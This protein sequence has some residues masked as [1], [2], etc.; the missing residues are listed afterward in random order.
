MATRANWRILHPIPY[1]KGPTPDSV[2]RAAK[3][4][5][6]LDID[7]RACRGERRPDGSYRDGVLVGLHGK[8]PGR[9]GFRW[10]QESVQHGIPQSKVGDLVDRPIS[11]LTPE[12]VWTLRTRD[13]D[14]IWSVDHLIVL[15][16]KVGAKLEF[17]AKIAL[18]L[19]Q[20]KHLK[21]TCVAAYGADDWRQMVW[22]K[23]LTNI[24]GATVIWR[25]TLRHARSIGF[26]TI[27]LR[28]RRDFIGRRLPV[29]HYRK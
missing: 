23:K 21:A 8:Y 18:T 27:A 4:G 10:T 17:E 6:P 14:R 11:A 24:F 13:G 16:A 15:A 22:V 9:E 2:R 26:R 5:I 20:L 1:L 3:L 29:T 28:V 25:P 19:G 12:V 7:V